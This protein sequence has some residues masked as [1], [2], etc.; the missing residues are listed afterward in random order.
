MR[1]IKITFPILF[2]GLICS[3]SVQAADSA[4]RYQAW[5]PPANEKVY[6]QNSDSDTHQRMI[7]QLNRLIND[8]EKARAAD[9]HFIQD[10]RDIL[11]QYDWPWRI[12]LVDEDFTDG[13][14]SRS[15]AWKIEAGDFELERGFGLRTRVTARETG[16][17]VKTQSDKELA[18]ALLGAIL[19]EAA[20]SNGG[21]SSQ[22]TDYTYEPATILVNKRISNAF[23]IKTTIDA[24]SSQGKIQLGLFQKRTSGSSYQLVFLPGP[25]ASIE[26]HRVGSRGSTIIDVADNIQA[27]GNQTHQ[28]QWTRDGKG[29]M[30]VSLNGE[31]IMQTS[32]RGLRDP[33]D[34]FSLSNHSGEFYLQHVSIFGI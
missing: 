15:P 24:R 22:D 13:N 27:K 34:G 9:R 17:S 16:R 26:L 32:D 11:S 5:Q 31:V 8:A 29:N 28:L 6:A 1:N 2:A 23:V 25:Q 14:V 4:S 33:F 21:N 18:V 3:A 7:D 12:T 10:L 30:T 20:K 19:N